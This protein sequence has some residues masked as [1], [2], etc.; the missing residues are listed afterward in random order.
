MMFSFDMV[1]QRG[2]SLV[3]M[4]IVI[5][6]VGILLGA[7]IVPMQALLI[8]DSYK[9]EEQRM[10]QLRDAVVGY[11]ARHQ[12][13]ERTASISGGGG[14]I[15]EMPAGRPYLPCPDVDGD[16]Y[17]DRN[18][19]TF[20]IGTDADI[21]AVTTTL[22]VDSNLATQGTNNLLLAGS[23]LASRGILPWKTLGGGPVDHWGNHY[24]YQVDDAFSNAI[25]G[26][27]GNTRADVFDLR[28]TVLATEAN[29][30]F[31]YA[32]R[33]TI[34]TFV[35]KSNYRVI[36]NISPEST[37]TTTVNT[38]L[39][40][41]YTNTRRPIVV[42]D[43]RA[44][45]LCQKSTSRT[46]ILEAG[47]IQEMAYSAPNREYVDGDISDGLPFVIVSHGKNGHGAVN[48]AA[49]QSAASVSFSVLI[50]NEPI[51][52]TLSVQPYSVADGLRHEAVNFPQIEAP[53]FNG[54]F[55]PQLQDATNNNFEN[56]Y[57][58]VAPRSEELFIGNSNSSD[59]FDDIVTWMTRDELV[60]VLTDG[61]ILP[62]KDVPVLK[63]Y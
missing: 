38:P 42:C 45:E 1:R 35:T 19:M 39:Q 57:F 7:V 52:N 48:Y 31:L 53:N 55:C 13:R 47:E 30:D 16:G 58:V 50:C 41:S 56:G 15:F 3:E 22:V 51:H 27:N 46:L 17:E 26:F 23:C 62:A 60:R 21:F 11:A 34:T 43:G 4:M 25:V 28:S 24:T 2:L 36:T 9:S 33:V 6:V 54:N 63:D 29:G 5:V 61:L 44:V 12:T 40:L 18:E 20:A 37:V 14:R 32:R 49:N 10:A 8:D 59:L